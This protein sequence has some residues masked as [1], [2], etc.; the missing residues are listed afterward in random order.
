[1]S[2]VT[3]VV[4]PDGTTDTITD[5]ADRLDLAAVA[6]TRDETP[7]P[8]P[9][10]PSVAGMSAEEMTDIL[11]TRRTA[12]AAATAALTAA[13]GTTDRPLDLL[14][15]E[16]RAA[17]V[18]H[19]GAGTA[20]LDPDERLA[21]LIVAEDRA[22]NRAIDLRNHAKIILAA[23]ESAAIS[24]SVDVQRRASELV[25]LVSAQCD[26]LPLSELVG[27][28]RGAVVA[29]DTALLSLFAD[30]LPGRLSTVPTT[31][32][33]RETTAAA[34]LKTLLGTVKAGLTARYANPETLKLR[35]TAT[36]LRRT[37]NAAFG[38]AS[39]RRV[40]ARSVERLGAASARV[41]IETLIP[42]VDA[43]GKQRRDADGAPLMKRYD[44][45]DEMFFARRA[46][47]AER[48]KAGHRR[49]GFVVVGTPVASPS[50]PSAPVP[51]P[52]KPTPA[53]GPGGRF[54]KT[55]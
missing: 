39:A 4:Y 3:T 20:G 8:P 10:L 14:T 32:N 24:L 29:N 30:L 52:P 17:A 36:A 23:T 1:M 49:T 16:G 48:E 5:D 33:H 38:T 12:L 18:A 27:R 28:V 55:R 22:L 25:P 15:A 13:G 50:H 35:E 31:A 51:A 19:R 7:D 9:P 40:K 26:K 47:D 6:P 21:A 42:I 45:T 41:G 34:E 37:A 11:E 46:L 44:E 2:V 53:R 54:T 43:D